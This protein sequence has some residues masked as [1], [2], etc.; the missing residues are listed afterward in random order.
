MVVSVAVVVAVVVVMAV[1]GVQ[2]VAGAAQV[3]REAAVEVELLF[4]SICQSRQRRSGGA[5]PRAGKESASESHPSS[6]RPS[7]RPRHSSSRQAQPNTIHC[8]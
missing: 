4:R 7:L 1:T 3:E 2:G 8:L 5:S 6:P